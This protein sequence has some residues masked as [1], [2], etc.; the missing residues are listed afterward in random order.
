MFG[1]GRIAPSASLLTQ[2]LITMGGCA[3]YCSSSHS[4]DPFILLGGVPEDSDPLPHTPIK[5]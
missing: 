1:G 5:P 3:W 4:P 2:Q